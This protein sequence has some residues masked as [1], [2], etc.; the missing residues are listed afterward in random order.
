MSS[1]HWTAEESE[2]IMWTLNYINT[3][4]ATRNY[5]FYIDLIDEIS[6]GPD[7]PRAQSGELQNGL[8][9]MKTLVEQYYKSQA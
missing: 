4:T 7:S 9:L 2:L 8:L 5:K 6:L 1:G 3:R